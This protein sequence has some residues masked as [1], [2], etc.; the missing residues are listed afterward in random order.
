MPSATG[1]IKVDDP[2]HD[3]QHV[4]EFLRKYLG[5]SLA[6]FEDYAGDSLYKITFDNLWML[7]DTGEDIYCPLKKGGQP[8]KHE[9]MKL[10]AS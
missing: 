7:F 5:T 2:A 10:L 8:S 3:F 6:L 1:D 9:A 4:V